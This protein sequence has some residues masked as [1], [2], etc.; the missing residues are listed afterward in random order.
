MRMRN[1]TPRFNTRLHAAQPRPITMLCGDSLFSECLTHPV[2]MYWDRFF[3]GDTKSPNPKVAQTATVSSTV[4]LVSLRQRGYGGSVVEVCS[5]HAP[6]SAKYEQG[7]FNSSERFSRSINEK[8]KDMKIVGSTTFPVKVYVKLNHDSP[9]ILCV[10]NRLRVSELIDPIFQWHGPNGDMVAENSSVKITPTGTLIFRHFKYDM[11]G[12]YT[13]SIVYKPTAE[14]SEKNYLIK[15]V[16]YAYSDP[17]YYYEFTARYHSAPCNS[18]YNVSFEKKLLQILA[19]LV[20]E[21]SCEVTLVQ[22]ECHH[23]KMQKAGLQNEIFFTF[24]V[25]SFEENKPKNRCQ[26]NTCDKTKRLNKAKDLI[27][28]FFK[29]Q[30]EVLGKRA[31]PLPE[32]YYIEGTLHIVWVNHCR[33][34]FGMNS[35]IHLDCPDCC[36]ICSPGTYNP[37]EGVHCLLCNRTLTYGA[38]KC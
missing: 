32:I 15:Y 25:S 31:N 1:I 5:F 22:S 37:S 9:R 19:K 24:R 20:A 6:C 36:V 3:L 23:V 30:V 4:A 7:I 2:N 33:P 34:G 13:C 8:S 29:E 17:D 35:L 28:K 27:E 21:L 11:S 10:T 38:T 16:I 26:K 18:I 14:Q 12:V